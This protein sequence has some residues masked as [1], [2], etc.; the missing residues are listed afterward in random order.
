MFSTAITARLEYQCGHA[1]LVSLPRIKGESP[2][3]RNARIALEKSSAQDRTCD[4]CAPRLE[5]TVEQAPVPAV[6]VPPVVAAPLPVSV[7]VVAANPA[8]VDELP[9][10][11]EPPVP[12]FEAP[13]P[14]IEV[15]VRAEEEQPAP[16]AVVVTAAPEELNGHAVHTA[17]PATIPTPS[18]LTKPTRPRRRRLEPAKAVQPAPALRVPRRVA[19][20]AP[21]QTF[22]IRYRGQQVIVA[23][24]I[25]DVLRQAE[26]LGELVA[27]TR[28]NR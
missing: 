15:P 1:A 10:P 23:R 5:L 2:A 3:Q 28:L 27:I 16:V 14:V 20:R 9:A 22:T 26:S 24:D 8:M 11:V 18:A 12:V 25:R 17:L 13:A 7:I 19:S 21:L 6:I 4:F